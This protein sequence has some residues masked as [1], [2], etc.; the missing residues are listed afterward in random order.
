MSEH[1]FKSLGPKPNVI[2]C[3]VSHNHFS[4]SFWINK[5]ASVGKMKLDS[6]SPVAVQKLNG[7]YH[8]WAYMYTQVCTQA[9]RGFFTCTYKYTTFSHFLPLSL[10]SVFQNRKYVFSLFRQIL[11]HSTRESLGIFFRALCSKKENLCQRRKGMNYIYDRGKKKTTRTSYYYH[12][13][14]LVKLKYNIASI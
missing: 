5:Y 2:L 11:T 13:A 3:L 1:K 10:S 14:K 6:Q 8:L 9:T 12:F 4:C 7:T